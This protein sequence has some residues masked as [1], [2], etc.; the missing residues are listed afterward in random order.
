MKALALVDAPDH[1]CCRYRIR[2][3]ESA[4][5]E[6]GWSLT[7]ERLRPGAVRPLVAARPGRAVRCRHRSAQALAGLAAPRAAPAGAPARLRLRRRG[8]LPR[9]VRPSRSPLSAAGATVRRGRSSVADV[10]IAGN[11]FL[12]E[13]RARGR[14]PGRS[15]PGDPH[16]HRHR[17]LP[18]S[19]RGGR[20]DSGAATSSGSARRARCGGWS[21]SDRS[22]SGS[23]ARS[24][25]SGS[26]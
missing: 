2:A 26:G 13:L 10:V 18:P 12:A 19:G 7:L 14:G 3:F 6:A 11:D 9:L 8:P 24:P 25:G 23:A 22:G 21:G 1:V 17:S 20:L 4:L 15:R 16:L 5:A